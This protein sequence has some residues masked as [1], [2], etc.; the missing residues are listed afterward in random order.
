MN[1][2]Q[3]AVTALLHIDEQ[4]CY[5]NM[6]LDACLERV[7]PTAADKALATR[8]LYGVTERRLTL[9]YLLNEISATP[10]KKMHPAVREILRVGV[11]QLVYMDKTPAYAAIDGA[12]QLTRA[13]GQ[14]RLAGFVNG[15]LRQV[16]RQ[17]G[18][19][20]ECLPS[21]DKGLERRYSC[22]RHWLRAWRDAY[23]EDV[24]Q[25]LLQTFNEAPPAYI[26]VNT[27]CGSAQALREQWEQAGIA[28]RPIEGLE[29][30][31]EILRPA[32]L[33][34]LPESMQR[35][36][37]FQDLASQWAC[38]ALQPLPG[39]RIA[40]V[41]AAPGGK[42]MTIAQMMG[43]TGHIRAGDIHEHKCRG[44]VQRV[45][46]YGFTCIEVEQHDASAPWP[47]DMHGMFDRV[48]CDVP[49]SGLGVIRRK[50]EIRYKQPADFAQLPTLQLR[51]LTQ[52]AALVRPGGVL[53][54]STCTLRPEENEQVA[55]AFLECHPAFAPRLLPLDVCFA[56]AGVP[57]SHEITLFPHVHGTDG[58]YIA[59]FQRKSE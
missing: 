12:V 22:P 5:S 23:G 9:D 13:M 26:R 17:A 52:A 28:C 29:N 48:V 25:G 2:R 45:K 24:L 46:Q 18:A 30:G 55:A 53:Q 4:G 11:Y 33:R 50:P 8:L 39:E 58:F 35:A 59:G 56:Q 31:F 57:A 40:D 42:T 6:A 43:D 16:Q 36:F 19:L 15:V 27:G 47:A 10:V 21:T 32:L 49:C 3:A 34:E 44:L 7:S 41:C 20:L 1:A 51:I 37:Y 38:Q 14:G 54:Y